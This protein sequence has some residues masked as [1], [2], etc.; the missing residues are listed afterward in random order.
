MAL[1][2]HAA[3][4]MIEDAAVVHGMLAQS[5]DGLKVSSTALLYPIV[6]GLGINK[7][8]KDLQ[9][10]LNSALQ[11]ARESGEYQALLARYGLEEPTAAEI[12]AAL[13]GPAR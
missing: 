7:E 9:R 1:R 11:R 12:Q 13:T 10:A 6:I 4:A 3:D 8:S 2:S 5:K